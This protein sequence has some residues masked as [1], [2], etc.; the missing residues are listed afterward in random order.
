MAG[1]FDAGISY[2]EVPLG[3]LTANTTAAT[4]LDSAA[5]VL[6]FDAEI[7]GAGIS[8][9]TGT[10]A[11]AHIAQVNL[12]NGSRGTAANLVWTYATTV[13]TVSSIRVDQGVVTVTTAS[14]HNLSVGQDIVWSTANADTTGKLSAG[15]LAELNKVQTVTSVPTTTTFTFGPLKQAAF[16]DNT[17]GF[18]KFTIAPVVPTTLGKFYTNEAPALTSGTSTSAFVSDTSLSADGSRTIVSGQD[19]AGK[20][21][22]RSTAV[23]AAGTVLYPEYKTCSATDLSASAVGATASL[24]NVTLQ[25]AVKKY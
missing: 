20:D 18:W 12:Y 1:N 9:V 24:T 11:A 8:G 14:A 15:L 16:Y 23:V 2:I 10:A 25:L 17:N 3:A 6:P 22:Y 5:F 4:I 13:S 21:V 7:V 19:T